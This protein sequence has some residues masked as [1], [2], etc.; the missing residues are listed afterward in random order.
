MS[1]VV[2]SGLG[3]IQSYLMIGFIVVVY[4]EIPFKRMCVAR[5]CTDG[6]FG[7]QIDLFVAS[8]FLALYT[9]KSG[10]FCSRKIF[11]YKLEYFMKSQYPLI[12]TSCQI[13]S[14]LRRH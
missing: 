2:N 14:Y 5:D 8:V 11:P 9:R 10:T 12:P 4:T 3:C 1:E 7:I 6:L 13:F